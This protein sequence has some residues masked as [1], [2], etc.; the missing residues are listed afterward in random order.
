M[1]SLGCRSILWPNPF[2]VWF[3]IDKAALVSVNFYVLNS[4][5]CVPGHETI[6]GTGLDW[7]LCELTALH[8]SVL[9]GPSISPSSPVEPLGKAAL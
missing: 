6:G 1:V 8:P 7:H 2:L 9:T 3:G 4:P 5:F